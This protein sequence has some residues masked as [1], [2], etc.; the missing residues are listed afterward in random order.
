MCMMDRWWS[1]RRTDW[2]GQRYLDWSTS[3]HLV[4]YV[5]VHV[6]GHDHLTLHVLDLGDI[7]L[8][9]DWL[10]LPSGTMIWTPNTTRTGTRRTWAYGRMVMDGEDG[11]EWNEWTW[12]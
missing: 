7:G 4:L 6:H 9:T 8:H 12:K 2:T 10:Y 1:G 3:D 5:T 11:N